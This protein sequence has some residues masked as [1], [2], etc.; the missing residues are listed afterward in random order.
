MTVRL[1]DRN[2]F[3]KIR[4]RATKALVVLFN[5]AAKQVWD[6]YKATSKALFSL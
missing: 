6:A 3:I 4:D 1:W 2:A 5:E